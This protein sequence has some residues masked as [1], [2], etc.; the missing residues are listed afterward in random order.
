M[1]FLIQCGEEGAGGGGLAMALETMRVS[2]YIIVNIID[3]F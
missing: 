2:Y 3:N 1:V